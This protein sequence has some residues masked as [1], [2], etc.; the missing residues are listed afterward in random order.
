MLEQ[1]AKQQRILVWAAGI[2][3]LALLLRVIHLTAIQQYSPFFDVFPGDLGSYDRWATNIIEQGWLGQE[4]FYQ[5]PLYPYFLAIIYKTI[6][7]DFFWVYMIQALLGA[8][9]AL[10]VFLLG[11]RIFNKATGIIGGLLYACFAPAIFF[12]GLLLKVSLAAFLFCLAVYFLV[13]KGLKEAGPNQILSG[14][15]M[16]LATLTRGNFLLILPVIFVALVLNRQVDMKRRLAMALLFVIGNLLVL[17]PVAARNY[18]VSNDLVLTTSQAGQNFY[19]GQNLEANGTYIKLSFVRPDPLFEQEDFHNEAEKRLGRELTPSEVSGYWFSQGMDFIKK[20]PLSFLKLTGKKLLLFFNNYEIPDNHNFYFHSKYSN[21]L[22]NLPISFGLISPFVILGFLGMIYERK[23]GSFFFF[24]IQIVYI[25]SIILFYI[26]SRYRMPVLPL[27]CISAGYGVTLLFRQFAMQKWGILALSLILSGTVFAMGR[28]PVIEPFD[29]S[30]SYTDEAIAHE[31]R[32][33]DLQAYESYR[34]ALTIKPDYLRALERFGK[35][36][37][38][39]KKYAEARQTF[40][41]ILTVDAES[42][43]AKY[44][45]MLMDKKGL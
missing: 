32:K 31:I 22:Q 14:F 15:F 40:Q 12:D 9:T 19:I 35:L 29:F 16:G 37:L 10:V 26:F 36:Q 44:Q 33:E 24:V 4:I 8:A 18:V 2:F 34:H 13:G 5:D 6:G 20:E 7:R 28:Y 3:F 39:L 1:E 27:L 25:G 11:S 42:V 17:V 38:K 23:T 21:V 45:I 41:R 43:E 30:H